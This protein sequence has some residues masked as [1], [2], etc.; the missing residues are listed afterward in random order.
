[1]KST[2]GNAVSVYGLFEWTRLCDCEIRVTRE[3]LPEGDTFEMKLNIENK[4]AM[5]KAGRRTF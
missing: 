4:P 5:Q 3:G 2:E 1:M